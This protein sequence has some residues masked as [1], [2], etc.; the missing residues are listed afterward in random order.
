MIKEKVCINEKKTSLS[1]TNSNISAVLKSNIQKTG[2]RLYDNDCLG[3]AGAIGSYDENELV[4]N[5]KQMLK[6]KLPYNGKP[7]AGIKRCIDLSIKLEM[8]NEEFVKFSDKLLQALRAKYG[9]FMFSHKIELIETEETITNDSGT[10]LV[11]REKQ[12]EVVLLN[13]H[14]ESKSMADGFG[15][16]ITR[17]ADF[18][19]AFKEMSWVCEAYD[20]KAD[21]SE[22]FERIPV[23]LLGQHQEFLMKFM[24]DLDGNAFGSGASLFSG[25][26]GEK[27]FNDNFSLLVN[28]DS[29][30]RFGCFFDGEGTVLPQDRFALIENGVLMSPYTT[31]R[32]AKKYDYSL[33][34]SASMGYDSAPSATPECIEVARSDKTIKELL[35]GRK[36]VY[37]LV[38]AGGDFTPQGEYASPIQTA[39]LYDGENYFGRLP[40]LSMSSNIYDMFGKDFIGASSVGSYPDCPCSYLALEMNVRKIDGWM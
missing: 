14:R 30:N 4:K 5:A 7:T 27:L 15:F 23:V 39:Y 36:A 12:L 20:E 11:H 28:R 2:I 40:Q 16:Y 1:I 6:F 38:A 21:F 3:I 17:E 33:T 19:T 29:E 13:K 8:S 37:A 10:D 22:E 25:K 26:T 34:G 35:G 31:K 32:I 24:I 18:D 9:N